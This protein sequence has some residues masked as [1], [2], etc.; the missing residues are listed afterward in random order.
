MQNTAVDIFEPEIVIDKTIRLNPDLTHGEKMFLAEI[1]SIISHQ[2]TKKLHYTLRDL[3]KSFNVSHQTIKNWIKK[4]SNLGFVEI[5]FDYNTKCHRHY[6][7]LIE[8]K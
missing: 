6:L 8:N 2:E 7:K 1:Q 3:S 4:L 5:G